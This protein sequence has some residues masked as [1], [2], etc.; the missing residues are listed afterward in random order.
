MNRQ[1]HRL[2]FSRRLGALVAVAETARA[3]GKAAS[4]ARA[5]TL[6]ASALLLAVPAEAQNLPV[7]S[8]GGALP[9]FV[10]AGQAAY[11]VQ[12]KQAYVNQVGNKAILNWQNFNVGAGHGVQ[13][14]QVQNLDTNALVQGASFTTLNRIW[15]INPSVIAGTLSQATGQRANVI[16]VN[17]NGIAFMGGSQVN[18]NSFTASTLNIADKFILNGLLGDPLSPQFEK[19]LDG[20]EAR[21][22]IEVMEGARISATSQGRVMLIAPDVVNRGTVEAP[23]GQVILAAGTR[24]YLRAD[25]SADL[26]L[27][28]LL[29]E[30]DSAA[31]GPGAATNF[32]ELSAARG[33]VT[34][35]GYAVNQMGRAS[36]TSSVVA[37]G[38]VYLMAKDTSVAPTNNTPRN[39]ARAGQVTLGQG[40]VTE[41]L[42]DRSDTATTV[43]SRDDQGNFVT[44]NAAASQVRVLGQQVHMAR[45]ATIHA[46]SGDVKIVAVDSPQSLDPV[47]GDLPPNTAPSASASLHIASGAVIDVAGL[48]DVQVSAGRNTLEVELRGDELKDSPLNQA[49]PLRG[50]SV[51]VDIEQALANA[52]AGKN[53]LIARDAL[54]AYRG[55]LERGVQER[56]TQGGTVSLQSQ[57]QA[58]VEQ[59]STIDLSGGSVAFQQAVVKT[60]VLGADGR[61]VDIADADADTRYSGIVSRYTVGYDRWN[62]EEVIELPSAWRV[63]TGYTEGRDAGALSVVSKGPLLLQADVQGRTVTGERQAFSGNGPRGAQLSINLTQPNALPGVPGPNPRVVI[64][65]ATPALPGGFTAHQALPDALKDTL[66]LDA[67]L[68]GKDRVAELNLVTDQAAEVRSALRAPQGGAV[69]ISAQDLKVQAD[70]DVSGGAI[71]LSGGQ[72]AIA[73][74][75]SLTARGAFVNRQ[76]GTPAGDG[77]RALV[78]GGSVRISANASALEGVYLNQGRVSLGQGVRI[79]ASGGAAIDEQGSIRAGRGGDIAITGYA[80]EGLTGTEL[81]A[82]GLEEGGSLTLGSHRVQIGGTAGN[83]F[84][85]LNLQGD[86]FT[87]GGFAQYTVNGL[88]RV[89]VAD[90]TVL[91]PTVVH[92]E[93]RTEALS[94]ASG[95]DL[96]GITRTVV[97]PDLQREAA[98]IALNARQNAADTGTLR[99]GEGARVEVDSGASITLSARNQLEVQGSVVARGGTISATLDRS[100][101]F[102]DGNRSQNNL[103]IGERA[104]LDASGVAKVFTDATGRTSGEVLAGGSVTLR[105]ATGVLAA[106]A[107]A[108][109]DVSGAGPTRLDVPN[110]NGGLGRSVASDAGRVSLFGENAI[111]F[112]ATVAAQAGAP[113][114]RGGTLD[115][116]LSQNVSSDLVGSQA[117]RALVLANTVAPQ[118]AGLSPDAVIPAEGEDGAVIGTAALQA[119]GFERMRFSSRDGVAL[120]DGLN[121]GAGTALREV[122]IDAGRV[123]ARGN[124]RISADAVRLTNERL[125]QGTQGAGAG[126][127]TFSADARLLE[128][129]GNLRLTGM[130]T[131]VLTGTEQVQLN[132]EGASATITSVGDL[133]LRGGV[134]TPGS[135]A[136]ISVNATGRDVRLERVGDSAVVPLS[137]LGRLRVEAQ[138]ITQAGR[139]VAPFGQIDLVAQDQLVLEDGSVTSV[140]ARP[141]Q[142]LLGGR[143]QNGVDWQ[144]DGFNAVDAL[145]EKSVRLSGGEVAVQ[146]GARVDVSG[147]GDLLAYEFTAGPGGSR[148]ILTDRNTYAI[149]PGAQPGFAPGNVLEGSDRPAGEAVYLQGVPGLPDG[150]YTLLP[151]HY[152]LLPGA[153]AVRLQEGTPLLP[154]QAYTRQ[155]GIRVA[156]GYVTDTRAGAPR[157]GD[158][159][160]IEVLTRDQVRRRSEFTLANASA[161]FADERNRTV[162]AGLLSV[163][164]QSRL[165]LEG[166]LVGQAGSGGRGAAVDISAPQLVIADPNTTGIDPAATVIDAARLNALDADSLLLGATRS[167]SG[168][169]TTLSVGAQNVT[170]ANDAQSVLA[171]PEVMLAARDTLTL[172][173]GSAI[174]A[175]GSGGDAGAY[176]T[177]G[178]G[179]LVR[180]ASTSAT[181]SRSGSP[182]R[183]AGTLLGDASSSI[184]AAR[185]ITLDA[186]RDTR[187][188]GTTAFRKDGAEVAGQLAIG[189]SRVSLGDGALAD[190]GLRYSQADLDALLGLDSLSLTSYSTVDLYGDVTVGGLDANGRPTLKNLTLQGAG[191]AGHGNAGATARVRAGHITLANAAGVAYAPA[192]APGTG[193]L[194]LQADTLTLGAGDKTLGGFANVDIAA[195]RTVGSG[196]GRTTL[197]GNATLRTAQLTGETGADQTLDAGTTALRIGGLAG[198]AAPTASA[199]LGAAWTVQAGAVEL[200]TT[201]ELGSGRFTAR[202]ESGDVVL[203]DNARVDVAGRG[204]RFFDQT[205]GS[206]GGSVTLDSAS[207]NVALGAGARIDVSAGAG[208]DAGALTLNARQGSVTAVAGNLEGR[209]RADTAGDRGDGARAHVDA[210]TLANVSALNAALQAGGFGG[211]RGLRARSGDIEIAAGDTVQAQRVTIS[212]DSGSIAVAGTVSASGTEGGQIGLYAGQNVTLQAGARVEAAAS[213][214]G[215][216]GGRVEIGAVGGT[217]DLRSGAIIDVRSGTGGEAGHVQL[218]AQRDGN[219]VKVAALQSDVLGAGRVDLEAV[220]VYEGITTLNASG[221][222]S[223]STLTLATVNTNDTAY[224]AQ[225]GAIKARLGQAGNAGFHIV[226]GSE[227]RSTGNLTLNTDWNLKDSGAGGEAGVLTLRAQGNLNLNNNLSDGFTNAIAAYTGN[228]N[229]LLDPAARGGQTWSYR[230]VAGADASAAN[231]MT[232]NTQGTGDLTVAAGKL[233]RTGSGDIR[234]AAG[235]DIRLASNT[236]VVYTAGRLSAPLPDFVAPVATQR[237]FFTEGGGDIE[238]RAGNDVIGAPSTQLYSNWLYRQ[239]RLGADTQTY[240]NGHG[241]TAWWVRFDQFNQGV[242]A[243]GGGDVTVQAGN[244]V[245]NLSASAPTQARMNSATADA[246]RLVKTGGG[247]VTVRAGGNVQGGQFHADEGRLK[248]VAGAAVVRPLLALGNAT[249]DVRGRDDVAIRAVINPHL[250]AQV[251]G[252]NNTSTTS[253]VSGVTTQID[254][255]TLFSTYGSDSAVDLASLLGD[256]TLYSEEG[257]PSQGVAALGPQY[258]SLFSTANASGLLVG[259]LTQLRNLLNVLPARLSMTAFKGDVVL[260]GRG[261]TLNML[262]AADGQL[263]LLAQDSVRLN[264]RLVMSDK[265][266]AATPSAVRPVGYAPSESDVL[267]P[268]RGP[269]NAAPPV[270]AGDSSTAKVYAVQGDVAG[271]SSTDVRLDLSK[272]VEVRA[273]RDV[274]NFNLRVQHANAGDRSVVEAG[275]DIGYESSPLRRDFDGIRIGGAGTLD[276]VAGRDINLGTSGGIVSRGDLDNSAL[277][278]TGATLRVMAGAGAQGLDAVGALQRLQQRL[279]SGVSDTDLWLA[280]WLTGN[281]TLTREAAPAALAPLAALDTQALGDRMRDFLFTALRET[282]R[283]ANRADSGYAGD[284]ARGYAALELL[285]PGI[286]EQD[287]QGR[288]NRYQGGINLFASR[289]KTER[290]GGIELLVPGG[291]V[292]VGLAN[293]PEALT[294]SAN[295]NLG[296]LGALGVVAAADGNVRAAARDDI[297]VNQS[298]ILTVL[299]GD[300]LLWSSEGDID[301]G[302]GKKTAATVPPPVIKTDPAT[303]AVTQEL[304][305]AATGSGI[306]ALRTNGLQAGDVDLIAPKGT[307]NAGDA[308]I[309]AGNLNIAAQVVLGADNI[310]VS[311]TSTGTPVAD[312]SAVTAAS[313]GATTGGDDASR[314]VEALNNA[315]AESAKAA[316]ELA[317]SLRPAVV[318]V[319]VLG[320][321]E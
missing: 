102:V 38:S 44:G 113:T 313:S 43:D 170:L 178:N 48:R 174:D 295:N 3:H 251:S 173:E 250:V 291:G 12:G 195:G 145:P 83:G 230:L 36:A 307:V 31:S 310:A 91:R 184:Q 180:A 273:G 2:V 135:N 66:T 228:T 26:N 308:G 90:N 126:I 221:A 256:V 185:S 112:D 231:P 63:T 104:L 303:G 130:G 119:A 13:F 281:R 289:I 159:Q 87:Q 237:A 125:A 121:L 157:Q 118:T 21:G 138:N 305:G 264:T 136:Q 114:Q 274:R 35:V 192:G 215:G 317:S 172:R 202:A 45:G 7:P 100:Q 304:Q 302:K 189:A 42:V 276:V 109:I 245:S 18:L 143:L 29:V 19:A 41:V 154:N 50:E 70:I 52:D 134:I 68:L 277:P 232:T 200:D 10:T 186:T 34:M 156:A 199:A 146:A 203:G 78:D 56:S 132:A 288:F 214:A 163:L 240:V 58:V 129:S 270:H 111:L 94:S 105:A 235:K 283:D 76:P 238:M 204:I 246:T 6:V 4:G 27:R 92:R 265:D 86:R 260:S 252:G 16:L 279:G 59:G 286:G 239:G 280:R 229:Q 115:V 224:A 167:T 67:D 55:R 17:S 25:D 191:L 319:D 261:G 103:W 197:Q 168:D 320:Y 60:T 8:A 120:A 234:M 61:A 175:Q 255:K 176:T 122:Q 241:Q 254:R 33:N 124:A 217:L 169:T 248:L 150:V 194:E 233:V 182:D 77:S 5:A 37:N 306:G 51:N 183:S 1:R 133:T 193:T 269:L 249:A 300:I 140:A 244:Q 222:S 318:R 139:V 196:Q 79:D 46:P 131:S 227:V 28:G 22:R 253:N 93:L 81:S 294:T 206:D 147:G 96:A 243:L 49:G 162:D 127:G 107:G 73:D 190:E 198:A 74:G 258:A 123:E 210:G 144:L 316:Q 272:A 32:G 53:T 57:G 285:F 23:D 312:T 106:E 72:V 207:G 211:E 89:E 108:R 220:R 148:D 141:G 15:D 262:P 314:V 40:S 309:R 290:G 65:R 14:R 321:G 271:A 188:D 212:A 263:E 47:S 218:R 287:A 155:D 293:T 165:A 88:D 80:V 219:D 160:A 142:V 299:G 9:N 153:L 116:T 11:Q 236:S 259:G 82:Y 177:A 311:G 62:R 152:A 99:I 181:F 101:G 20:G 117:P 301:A 149:L 315:A 213:A 201:V 97:R 284:F 216:D 110:E 267:L 296:E 151:A 158:W 242:G 161:F 298:R 84:G 24:A 95:T 292:V 208:A 226:S 257:D 164:T 275:R 187:F 225:H 179:A 69:R 30:V 223:G 247:D 268:N 71:D 205:R 64:D 128:V 98:S 209:T 278:P 39:S 166:T 266:P 137:A 171:A 85:Q 75:V 54:E 297:L 282:G